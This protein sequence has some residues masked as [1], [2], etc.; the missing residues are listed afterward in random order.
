MMP[1]VEPADLIK[2]H[3]ISLSFLSHFHSR[4]TATN[5]FCT[6]RAAIVRLQQRSY[7]RRILYKLSH[8]C[9]NIY[10]ILHFC[11]NIKKSIVLKP[12]QVDCRRFPCCQ[13]WELFC[14]CKLI[15]NI[16]NECCTLLQ[17]ITILNIES[18]NKSIFHEADIC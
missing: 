11:S 7:N 15:W 3:S 5:S 9:I 12:S 18:A 8:V 4:Q 2:Y 6:W 13:M 10:S 16:C 17:E 14:N 1:K